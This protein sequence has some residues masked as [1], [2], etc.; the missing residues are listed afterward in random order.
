M[1]NLIEIERSYLEGKEPAEINE[2]YKAVIADIS[3]ADQLDIWRQVCSFANVEMIAYLIEQGWTAARMEDQY[4]NTLLHLLTQPKNA[5]SYFIAEQKV[6]ESTKQL[7]AAKVSPLRKN[8]EGETALM[9]AARVGYFEMLQAYAEAGAKIDFTDREGNT[10][11]HIVAKYASQAVSTQFEAQ[12]KLVTNQNDPV[13][14]PNSPRD[15]QRRAQ[16]EWQYNVAY[17]RHNQFIT[18]TLM[19][20]EF[21]IDPYQKN[22]V[23]ETAV[24]VAIRYRAKSIGAILNGVDLS[25][26][27]T[28]PLYFK[29]GG[30]NIFQACIQGDIEALQSLIE[31]GETLNEAYDKEGDNYQ[32]MTALSIA[33]TRHSLE[34][35]G[36]LLKGGADPM[37]LDSKSW[38]P[39]RYLYTP[40]SNTNTNF[41]EFEQKTF[42]QILK[43]YLEAGFDINSLLDDDENTLLTLTAKYADRLTLYNGNT[44][45]TV[46]IEETIYANA[47]LNKT[48]RE[49]VSALMYLC[50]G[51]F[52]RAEKNLLL[53]LEQGASTELRDKSG[54]TTLIYAVSNSDQSAAK[55]YAELLAEFG[56]LLLDTKDN[57]EKSALDYAAAQNNEALVAWILG[58]M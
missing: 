35:T 6:Y 24:D 27:K 38:H 3:E 31:L 58:K 16:L 52:Q 44:I 13:F 43:A 1:I 47:D 53:L 50:Q 4:G 55:T 23:G 12:E 54:K 22:N 28:A 9:L 36:V 7:L 15:V 33:M 42:Q 5:N 14:D 18:F 51:D 26:E 10:I 37:L 32:G 48:N 49:G 30:M 21:G 20:M 40:I 56:N 46:L 29:A 45:A 57:S 11:L 19:A 8:S 25:D 2:M 39:F 41:K 34:C 17:A